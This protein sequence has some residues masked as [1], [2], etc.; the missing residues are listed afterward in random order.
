MWELFPKEVADAQM[1]CI[2]DVIASGLGK[3]DVSLTM[4]QG[5]PRWYDTTVEPLCD[6]RGKVAAGLL[7]ARDIHDLTT[8]RQDLETYREKMIH[9]EHLASLGTLSAMLSHEMMQPLTVLR[10]S[11]QNAMKML[12]E[13]S[14]SPA[15]LEDLNEGLAE[16]S[17]VT[18][19]LHR[20]RDFA[21]PVSPGALEQVSLAGVARRVA[22]LLEE[23]ARKARVALDVE[24]LERLPPIRAC[25]KDLEQVFFILTQNAIQAADGAQDHCFRIRGVSEDGQVRVQFTDDCGGIAPQV[26]ERLFEP[27]VTTKPAGEGLGLGLCVVQRLVSHVGG[28]LTVDSRWGEGTTFFLTWPIEAK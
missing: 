2:R 21:G 1:T 28:R 27:F 5:E 9:A 6:G 23:S 10:L 19:I 7:F 11:I 18:A 20:F 25:G 13:A 16:V 12:E 15:A 24:G 22:R 14:P 3:R 26:R 4:V 17:H 8:A